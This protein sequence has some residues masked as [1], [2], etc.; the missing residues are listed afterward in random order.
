MTVP[1]VILFPKFFKIPDSKLCFQKIDNFNDFFYHYI[2]HLTF[3]VKRLANQPRKKQIDSVDQK[4][5]VNEIQFTSLFFVGTAYMFSSDGL[6]KLLQNRHFE[7]HFCIFN[8]K[9][10][11]SKSNFINT[12]K[13][14]C[15]GYTDAQNKEDRLP[16]ITQM[17]NKTKSGVDS[18]DH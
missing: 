14:P 4:N 17:Y 1:V 11:T 13:S 18:A 15:R 6:P 10:K 7:M 12:S 16:E 5:P 9:K 2:Q 3:F 8:T